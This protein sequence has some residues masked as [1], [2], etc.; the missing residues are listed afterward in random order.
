ME[1]YSDYILDLERLNDL[2]TH[3]HDNK[4]ESSY[5]N[6]SVYSISKKFLRL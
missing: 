5:A 3:P 2:S 4:G 1:D 6:S